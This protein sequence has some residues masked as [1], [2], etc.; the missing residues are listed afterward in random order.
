M[1][2]PVFHWLMGDDGSCDK[3][4]VGG[5]TREE[6]RGTVGLRQLFFS[7][8][9]CNLVCVRKAR[10]RNLRR[11]ENERCRQEKELRNK[12]SRRKLIIGHQEK[13]SSSSEIGEKKF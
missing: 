10:G 6:L 13:G 5:E 1:K 7:Q 8:G 4:Q 3:W 9:N 2:S 11:Q 12:G